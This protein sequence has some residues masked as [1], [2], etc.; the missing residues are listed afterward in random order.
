MAA[1]Y[2]ARQVDIDATTGNVVYEAEWEVPDTP[3]NALGVM[4]T[5]NVVLGIWSLSDAANAVGL[6]EQDL[7]TEAQSWAVAMELNSG[8]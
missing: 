5:L 8:N 3:L 4:A 6:T 1:G 2:I 7:I